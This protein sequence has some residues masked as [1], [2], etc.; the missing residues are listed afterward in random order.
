[1]VGCESFCTKAECADLKEQIRAIWNILEGLSSAFCSKEDCVQLWGQVLAINYKLDNTLKLLNTHIDSKAPEA[2]NACSEEECNQIERKAEEAKAIALLAKDLIEVHS[3]QPLSGAHEFD[4]DVDV[5]V[6]LAA[7]KQSSSLVIYTS[8]SV[9]GK[10]GSDKEEIT[11]NLKDNSDDFCT[12]EECE[13][14]K[15]LIGL[16]NLR[17]GDLQISQSAQQE[18]IDN[19]KDKVEKTN[20]DNTDIKR[21]DIPIPIYYGD[22][23]L[24]GSTKNFPKFIGGGGSMDLNDLIDKLNEIQLDVHQCCNNI[25]SVG[26]A[27]STVGDS[28]SNV[29]EGLKQSSQVLGAQMDV[30]QDE[31]RSWFN[32]NINSNNQQ[33]VDLKEVLYYL[34]KVDSLLNKDDSVS[35]GGCSLDAATGIKVFNPTNNNYQISNI[36]D[37]LKTMFVYLREIHKTACE[38][39]TGQ[40]ADVEKIWRLLGGDSIFTANPDGTI[41]EKILNLEKDMRKDIDNMFYPVTTDAIKGDRLIKHLPDYLRAIG[42]TE[43]YRSGHYKYDENYKLIPDMTMSVQELREALNLPEETE[44]DFNQLT[45]EQ[46]EQ[47]ATLQIDDDDEKWKWSYNQTMETLGKIPLRFSIAKDHPL[48]Q[49]FDINSVEWTEFSAVPPGFFKTFSDDKGFYKGIRYVLAVKDAE[50][51]IDIEISSLSDGVVELMGLMIASMTNDK[52]AKEMLTRQ[53]IETASL[54]QIL[55]TSYSKLEAVQ[56]YLGC[57]FREKSDEYDLV[58][59]PTPNDTSDQTLEMIGLLEPTKVNYKR[60]IFGKG[61]NET[62]ESK[63]R[64]L[65]NAAMI[66]KAKYW[67]QIAS[68]K[69]TTVADET[70]T[71][72]DLK[73][74]FKKALDLGAEILGDDKKSPTEEEPNKTEFDDFIKQVEYGFGQTIGDI[75]NDGNTKDP[76]GR[77]KSERPKIQRFKDTKEEKGGNV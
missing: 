3:D 15:N 32:I 36:N 29:N 13:E 26:D 56:A 20:Q 50:K 19:L 49:D 44:I 46:E 62:L 17:I 63:L 71:K 47:L 43:H 74:K 69:S 1:M 25:S 11:L 41:Q 39:S 54:K 21:G 2:H 77:D 16:N 30:N 68:N 34:K 75:D 64:E 52:L 37:Y 27:V 7:S 65:L 72:V 35:T 67:R 51:D 22:G 24:V 61:H 55:M 60:D 48:I 42:A 31:A 40:Q 76:Y 59:N 10:K 14:L 66:I 5:D 73:L 33:S 9:C 6:S 57:D 45:E 53:L 23:S 12:K 4:C 18:D 38:S 58:F 8:V 70:A 28:V